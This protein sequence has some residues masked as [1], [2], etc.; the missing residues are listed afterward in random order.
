M[1]LK[2]ALEQ[3][4]YDNRMSEINVKQGWVTPEEL[5]K[6]KDQLP[7]SKDMIAPVVTEN[8]SNTQH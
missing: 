6:H 1:G 8:E 2:E 3:L 7:D 5:K 4:K